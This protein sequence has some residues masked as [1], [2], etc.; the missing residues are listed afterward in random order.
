MPVRFA[1]R[2]LASSRR[3]GERGRGGRGGGGGEPHSSSSRCGARLAGPGVEGRGA[4][5]AVVA[6]PPDGRVVGWRAP[7]RR[8]VG[9]SGRRSVVDPLLVYPDPPPVLLVQTL[10]L[11]GYGWKAVAHASV[12][13]EFEPV[14][15][16]AGAVVAA[17]WDPE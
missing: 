9:W 11:A 13:A 3:F 16:W 6:D 15:G 4:Q 1:Y 8:V 7:G 5:T 12:A 17:E 14:D 2:L 10:D